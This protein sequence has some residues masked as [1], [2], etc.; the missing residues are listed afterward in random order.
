MRLPP[1]LLLAPL[2]ATACAPAVAWPSSGASGA[3]GAAGTVG[4]AAERAAEALHVPS[5]PAVSVP[6]AP[7][8]L[9][10]AESAPL[11]LEIDPGAPDSAL[12]V[13]AIARPNLPPRTPWQPPD[14]ARREF[15][16]RIERWRP[17]VRLVLSEEWQYGT[18]DGPAQRIDDDFILAV[19]Q[20]ESQGNPRAESY[21]GAM[22]LMQVMPETFAIVMAGNK[23]LA[24]AIPQ[25]SFWDESSNIRAG[26]RYLALA[27][28]NQDGNY[29]WSLAS[30]NAG[31]GT[32]KRWRLAGLYAVPPYGPYDETANYAQIIM[33]SYVAHR[34]GLDLY[35]PPPMPD[36]HVPGALEMIRSFRTATT[37]VR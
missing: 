32:V 27:M 19:I 2:L 17:L 36:E 1:W 12:I 35:I 26:I 3:A 13:P 22:G 16:A 7:I 21:V 10:P 28:Q 20:Q 8:S 33:R 25:D 11:R 34:P 29:Y 23:S 15:P 31:I 37:R 9:A 30:Y 18:L 6:S 14:V 4:Q 24:P 5:G